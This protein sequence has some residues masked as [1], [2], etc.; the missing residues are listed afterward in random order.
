ME[1]MRY[2]LFTVQHSFTGVLISTL[3]QIW[4]SLHIIIQI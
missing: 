2:N 1:G 4:T 3:L